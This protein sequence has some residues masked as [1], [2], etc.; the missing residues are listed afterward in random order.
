MAYKKKK[1]LFDIIIRGQYYNRLAYRIVRYSLI[2]ATIAILEPLSLWLVDYAHELSL[3]HSLSHIPSLT[4]FLS[5]T[6][7]PHS[8]SPSLTLSQPPSL[9]QEEPLMYL[10]TLKDTKCKNYFPK[11]WDESADLKKIKMPYFELGA[12]LINKRF[13]A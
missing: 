6:L 8:L 13:S 3:T 10:A 4:L 11:I 2:L 12:Q 5:L 7:S 1:W 9:S